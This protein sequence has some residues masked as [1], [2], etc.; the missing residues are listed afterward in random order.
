M[1]VIELWGL[2]FLVN[3]YFLDISLITILFCHLY[4]G[5]VFVLLDSPLNKDWILMGDI[6]LKCL[7]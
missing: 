4:I 1:N 3:V 7:I 5:M 2:M 6:G